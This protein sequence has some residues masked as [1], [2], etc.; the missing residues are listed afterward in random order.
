M[1]GLLEDVEGLDRPAVKRAELGRRRDMD[2]EAHLSGRGDRVRGHPA[3]VRRVPGLG[4]VREP[5]LGHEVEAWGTTR[6]LFREDL[7]HAGRGLRAIERRR[8]RT[9]QDLDVVDRLRVDVVEPRR[10]SAAAG[11]DPVGVPEATAA[12]HPHAIHVHDRFVRLGQTGGRADPDLR[13]LTGESSARQH[14]NRGIA[15]RQLLGQV[16]DRRI[17]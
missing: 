2:P 17:A 10:S 12:I 9:F 6:T 14:R 3:H 7:N 13:P 4:I 1:V 16:G 15:G 5:Q 8:G 11:A